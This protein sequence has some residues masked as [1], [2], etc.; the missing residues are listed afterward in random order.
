M[1]FTYNKITFKPYNQMECGGARIN[2]SGA[3]FTRLRF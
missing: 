2:Y 1:N 3:T